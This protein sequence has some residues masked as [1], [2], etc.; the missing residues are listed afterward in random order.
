MKEEFKDEKSLVNRIF[1]ELNNNC[2][3]GLKRLY[4]FVNLANKDFESI[5]SGWYEGETPPKLEIDMIFTFEDHQRIIDDALIIG[6]EIKYFKDLRG[7]YK[8]LGQILSYTI[9]GFDGLSLW[10]LFPKEVDDSKIQ[11]FANATKEIIEGFNLSI[12]YICGRI[13]DER[14][15]RIKSFAPSLVG[16]DGD[17][18]YFVEWMRNSVY[19]KNN[20]NLLLFESKPLGPTSEEIRKRRKTLKVIL[21]IP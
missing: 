12:F 7:F 9:F 18:K 14:E 3:Y 8:G 10:H 16:I 2:P 4:K 13:I 5:W 19:D 17:I 20:R 11:N 6:V 15:L 1:E 21:K